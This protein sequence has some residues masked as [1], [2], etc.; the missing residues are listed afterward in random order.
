MT[1]NTDEIGDGIFEEAVFTDTAPLQRIEEPVHIKGFKVT[2][3]R[4]F[5]LGDFESLHAEI[6]IWVKTRIPENTPFDLHDCKRRARLMARQNI[7]AQYQRVAGDDSPVFLGLEPP[8]DGPAVFTGAGC[9]D[10][11]YVATVGVGLAQ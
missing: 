3:D 7:K 1:T 6:S 2:Y 4:K 11:I 8:A 9:A 5:N 10:P